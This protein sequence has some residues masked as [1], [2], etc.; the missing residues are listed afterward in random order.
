VNKIAV[1]SIGEEMK[2]D[3]I[4]MLLETSDIDKMI[5]ENL[6]G[7]NPE[8]ADEYIP[9]FSK[10]MNLAYQVIKEMNV[11]NYWC[12]CGVLSSHSYASF[13]KLPYREK[14]ERVNAGIN[15]LPLAICKSAL[16]EILRSKNE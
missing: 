4:S 9:E 12:F 3:Y 7:W 6:I 16:K 2:E 14:D 1:L 11:H 13:L 5:V 8:W 15:E 10:D